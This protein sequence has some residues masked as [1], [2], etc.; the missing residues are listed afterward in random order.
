MSDDIIDKQLTNSPKE[1]FFCKKCVLSNQRPRLTFDS[2]GICSACKFGEEKNHSIDWDARE[3]EL[4]ELCNKY[5]KSNGEYD[6]IVPGS[7]GKDSGFVAHMLKTKYHMHPLTITWAPFMYT[8]I[9][10]KN[11]RSF[12]DSGFTNLMCTPNGKLHR[13]LARIGFE[14]VG[15]P[16]LPFIYGQLAFAF[17]I[18]LKFNV[19]LVFFGENGE[20]E[21]G[22]SNKNNYKPFMPLEDWCE[23]YFKGATV[24][25]LIKWGLEKNIL[26][27]SDFTESDLTFYRPPLMEDIKDKN[28][29][30][31]W[32]SYYHKWSP[33]ENYQYC[34]KHTG[35][36]PNTERSEGTYTNFASLDD[37]LDGIHY[38]LSYI[39]FGIGRATSDAA[40]ETRDG[41][42]TREEAV[43][44]VKKYDS[45]FPM[46][47]FKECL[48]YLDISEDTF[49]NTINK[50]RRASP[51]L[52]EETSD[53]WKLKYEVE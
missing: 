18:A 28:I 33:E 3:K 8:D 5:R 38:Y 50:F 53:G 25:D 10:W 34:L 46:K 35:F 39:K 32:F 16:F 37:K 19:K 14:A 36:T 15:D 27:E 13:K 52:W 21:Y 11:Y 24:D 26:N 48:E 29:Q 2:N 51:H 20:A 45:E 47:Y 22:G 42:I 4:Q 43:K 23:S 6:V 9:G 1:V 41:I 30:M 12:I 17:H 7:G 44:L 40:H 31:H 49:W